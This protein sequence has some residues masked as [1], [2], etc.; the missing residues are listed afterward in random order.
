LKKGFFT[1]A[2]AA[3][4]QT[5][6]G[7]YLPLPLG[8]LSF[9]FGLSSFPFGLKSFPLPLSSFPLGVQLYQ[10]TTSKSQQMSLGLHVEL[11]GFFPFL[12]CLQTNF[13][14]GHHTWMLLGG[15]EFP[16]FAQALPARA[17]IVK[18]STN[19]KSD[20][21]KVFIVFLT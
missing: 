18:Q 7:R 1:V 11:G 10:P 4:I 2:R 8:V 19:R 13:T 16:F 14:L 17:N 3:E 9:P 12:H 20:R 6:Q 15:E 21:M 5:F